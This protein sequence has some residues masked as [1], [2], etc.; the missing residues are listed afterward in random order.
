M[1]KT[2]KLII[3]I[4]LTLSL[5]LTSFF[6]VARHFAKPE[7]FAEEV[8]YL[9][10]K[11]VSVL[12][13]A[14]ASTTASLAITALPGDLAT[15]IAEKITDLSSCFLLIVGAVILEKYL[16]TVA[17]YAAFRILIPLAC[18]ILLLYFIGRNELYKKAAV[19][20]LSFSLSIA[21]LIP[22]S[23]KVSQMIEATY[24]T[25]SENTV[26][27]II[28]TTEEMTVTE[29]KTEAAPDG[30]QSWWESIWQE[31]KST[32][33][34]VTNSV[35]AVP[36]KLSELCNRF[37]E[38]I[39]VLIITSCAIPVLVL[40]GFLWLIKLFLGL[41]ISP[42]AFRIRAAEKPEEESYEEE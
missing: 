7:S 41:E 25:V 35:V 24:D 40:L 16:L 17:S 34:K 15:P 36:E 1:N 3:E 23:I 26:E 11:R 13:L 2:V 39:A 37:I 28:H 6:V 42:A 10:E 9:D 27:A 12:E 19:K 29:P 14:G 31:A 4:V 18:V 32:V 38:A 21:L 33:D 8:A 30:E 5:M 22:V 20:L